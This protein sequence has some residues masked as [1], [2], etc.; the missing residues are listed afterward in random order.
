[1][2]SGHTVSK[3]FHVVLQSVLKLHSLF[4]LQPN[5]V[6]EDNTDPRWKNFKGCLGVLDVTYVDIHVLTVDQARYKNRKGQVTIKVLGVCDMNMRFIYVLTYSYNDGSG[7]TGGQEAEK[8]KATGG[9]RSWSKIE[10][11]AL[12]Q[13]L[14]DIV[15]NSWRADNGFKAGFQ[16]ELQKGMCALMHGTD[17]LANPHIN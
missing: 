11:D 12:V 14:I 9:R 4:L 5:L 13:C 3:Y 8:G 10:E 2:R 7:N 16:R 15:N 6:P 17:I 1:M